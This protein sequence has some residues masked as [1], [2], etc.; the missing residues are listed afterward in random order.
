MILVSFP[1]FH[2]VG[3]HF[4]KWWD[5][6]YGQKHIQQDTFSCYFCCMLFFFMVLLTR[7]GYLLYFLIVEVEPERKIL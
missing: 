3:K 7:T 5:L 2:F 4:S 1:F 6:T